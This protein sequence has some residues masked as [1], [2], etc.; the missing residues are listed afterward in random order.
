MKGYDLKFELVKIIEGKVVI[1]TNLVVK[2]EVTGPDI[3]PDFPVTGVESND[4]T[5]YTLF[6]SI[7]M[8]LAI[9]IKKR[10]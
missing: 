6:T 2:Y 3:D 5:G 4:I 8:L 10:F 1:D 7:L 9:I